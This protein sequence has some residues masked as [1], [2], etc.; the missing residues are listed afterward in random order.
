M[1]DNISAAVGKERVYLFQDQAGFHRNLEVR[2]HSEKL[3]IEPIW[4]VAY[5][6]EFNPVERLWI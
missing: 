4:N 5:R 6:F 3:N 1:L 2:K